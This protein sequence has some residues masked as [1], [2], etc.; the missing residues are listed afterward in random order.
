MQINESH[1]S[2]FASILSVFLD[3]FRSQEAAECED[4]RRRGVREEQDVHHRV[5]GAHPAGG[6]TETR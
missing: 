4:H 5:G 2:R 6:G 3:L 1:P